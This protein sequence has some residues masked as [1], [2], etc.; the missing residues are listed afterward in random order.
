MIDSNELDAKH[1]QAMG[2]ASIFA[3]FFAHKFV[4]EARQPETTF[5]AYLVIEAIESQ[6]Q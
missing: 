3:Q 1:R 6:A 4:K 2:G 5:I